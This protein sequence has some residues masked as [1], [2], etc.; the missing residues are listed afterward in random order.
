M[1][2]RIVNEFKKEV[3][4]IS[5]MLIETDSEYRDRIISDAKADLMKQIQ[6]V[7]GLE[8]EFFTKET[9]PIPRHDMPAFDKSQTKTF[10]RFKLTE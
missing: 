7:I 8:A 1:I 6:K 3:G 5:A 10:I 2:E 4:P 9:G